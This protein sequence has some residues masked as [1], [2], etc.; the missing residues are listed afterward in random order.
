MWASY[1][2]Q[3]KIIQQAFHVNKYD[4]MHILSGMLKKYL[5]I[6]LY[7]TPKKM[8]ERAR[9]AQPNRKRTNENWVIKL[10]ISEKTI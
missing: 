1:R 10:S 6:S 9:H 7:F 2:I 3:R 5:K 4:C 8:Q